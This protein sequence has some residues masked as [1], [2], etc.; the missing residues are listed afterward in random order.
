MRNAAAVLALLLLTAPSAAARRR[1]VA[2]RINPIPAAA[3]WLQQ[4]AVPFATTEPRTPLD[5]L[6]PLGAILGDARIVAL[7]EATHGSREFFTMKHRILELLVREHGFTVFAIEA[8]VADADRINAYVLD[9]IGDPADLLLKMRMWTWNTDEVLDLIQWMREY[10]L[11]RGSRPPVSF[12]GYDIQSTDVAIAAIDAYLLRVDPENAETLSAKFSCFRRHALFPTSTYRALAAEERDA[13]AANLTA[14]HNDLA[15]RREAYI[16]RS[17]A[18]E[19][20]TILHY[21]RVVVQSEGHGA[22]RAPGRDPWMA[23][24]AAWIAN[25]QHA[26]E[27]IVLWAHN[28]HVTTETA[29]RMGTELRRVFPPE[30]MITVGFVFDRGDFWAYADPTKPMTVHHL[31]PWPQA[32]YEPLFRATGHDLFF[33]DLRDVSSAEARSIFESTSSIWRIG[34]VF[35]PAAEAMAREVTTLSRAFDVVIWIE[36]VTPARQ[37]R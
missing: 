28:N 27:K 36:S 3:A 20:Q 32:L 9:G 4:N 31:E 25:V 16:A 14:L 8:H 24:N 15:A 17:S 18:G 1:A 35:N 30:V 29:S 6:A 21:A 33:V 34:G 7:G 10:N 11:E 12:R 22:G 2:P 23:E 5:D 13:C 26:G 19:Y 37:R